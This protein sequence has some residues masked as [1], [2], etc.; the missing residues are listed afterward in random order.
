MYLKDKRSHEQQRAAS[1][2]IPVRKV[3]RPRSADP[4]NLRKFHEIFWNHVPFIDLNSLIK[5]ALKTFYLSWIHDT[6]NYNIM[7]II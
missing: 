2:F 1:S 7:G 6:G 5:H 4:P 3:A